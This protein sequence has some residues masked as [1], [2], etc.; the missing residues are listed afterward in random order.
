MPDL[1]EQMVI[2]NS[3]GL[4]ARP[5]AKLVQTVLQYESDVQINVNG[6]RVNAKSIMGLLTL[7]AAQGTQMIVTAQG[8]D[9]EQAINAVRQ[10]VASGFGEE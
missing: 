2:V 10:L 5:A 8:P 6:Q 4:H 3:M 7:A 9:A 1:T